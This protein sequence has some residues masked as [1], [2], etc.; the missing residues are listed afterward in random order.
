MIKF[1]EISDCAYVFYG[2]R[3]VCKEDILDE[4]EEYR[5]GELFTAIEKKLNLE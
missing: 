3:L 4:L 2:D 1:S 5:G